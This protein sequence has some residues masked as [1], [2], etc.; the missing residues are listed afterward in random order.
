MKKVTI[1]VALLAFAVSPAMAVPWDLYAIDGPQDP[2]GVHH[3]EGPVEHEFGQGFP[4]EELVNVWVENFDYPDTSCFDG[5]DDPLIANILLGVTN[6]TNRTVPLWY[7]ADPETTISNFDGWIGNVGL[8]DEEEAFRIDSVGINRPLVFESLFADDLLQPGET[9]HFILQDYANAMG[10][11]PA[12]MASQ[13][14]ASLSGGDILSSGS[15]VPEPATLG[16]L[17]LGG[18][19]LLRRK[20]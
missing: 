16:L 2:I 19:A 18:L 10:N 14:V 11:G 17:C 7:V 13:G 4:P 5:S 12:Q 15:L 8:A 1:V 9:W 20:K 3:F 6:L